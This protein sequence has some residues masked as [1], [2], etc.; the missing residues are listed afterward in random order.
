MAIHIKL[1]PANSDMKGSEAM[2]NLLIHNKI[3]L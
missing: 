3:C 2:H 1:E